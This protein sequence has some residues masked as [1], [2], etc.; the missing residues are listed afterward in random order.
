MFFLLRIF[1]GFTGFTLIRA[2]WEQIQLETGKEYSLAKC[3]PEKLQWLYE[4]SDQ[5]T[6]AMIKEFM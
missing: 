3:S 1:A 4:I 2:V 6:K 5:E